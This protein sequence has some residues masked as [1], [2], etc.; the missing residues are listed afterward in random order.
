MTEVRRAKVAYNWFHGY[1][2]F[3]SGVVPSMKAYVCV[4]P[5]ICYEKPLQIDFFSKLLSIRLGIVY[6]SMKGQVISGI[7]GTV[8]GLL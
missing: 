5:M 2:N 1:T 3:Y 6:E 8:Y 7:A 4:K